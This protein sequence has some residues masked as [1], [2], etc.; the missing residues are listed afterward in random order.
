MNLPPLFDLHTP[1]LGVTDL[2]FLQKECHLVPFTSQE[3]FEKWFQ[4]TNMTQSLRRNFLFTSCFSFLYLFLDIR[5]AEELSLLK[6]SGEYFKKKKKKD[7]NNKEPII[8]DILN[9]EGSPTISGPSGKI[10][11]RCFIILIYY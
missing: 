1:I 9:L 10:H 7:K 4:M 3:F 5:R 2:Q 6:P 8:E 11:D